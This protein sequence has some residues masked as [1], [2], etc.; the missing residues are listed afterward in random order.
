MNVFTMPQ[1]YSS[2][3]SPVQVGLTTNNGSYPHEDAST[4][5]RRE[6][7]GSGAPWIRI[8]R[9]VELTWETDGE[10][11]TKETKIKECQISGAPLIA[12]LLLPDTH[13]PG[14]F[15]ARSFSE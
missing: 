9:D 12:P 6:R 13:F 10:K 14:L 5:A 15:S 4:V 7:N 8:G 2:S 1:E 11:E 3:Y